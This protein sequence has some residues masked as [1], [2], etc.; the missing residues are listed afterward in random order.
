MNGQFNFKKRVKSKIIGNNIGKN[1]KKKS[2]RDLFELNKPK[3]NIKK[4]KSTQTFGNYLQH[5][6]KE[7]MK[8]EKSKQNTKGTNKTKK[9]MST[10]DKRTKSL[11]DWNFIGGDLKDKLDLQRKSILNKGKRSSSVLGK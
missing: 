11:D 9:T 5:A 10:M 2:K 3:V 4:L 7:S 8:Q 6:F 1:S